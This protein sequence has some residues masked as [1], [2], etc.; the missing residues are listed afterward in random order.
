[1]FV[2]ACADKTTPVSGPILPG[3]PQVPPAASAAAWRF[4]VNMITRTVKITPPSPSLG[5]SGDLSF[6]AGHGIQYSLVGSDVISLT[7]SNYV[8]SGVGTGGAQPGRVLVTFDLAITNLLTSVDLITPTFPVPPSGVSGLFAFPF[9]TNVTTTTGGVNPSGGN[10]VIIDVPSHGMVNPS[11]H[12]GGAPHNFFND[13][14][15]PAG[16]NDCY[17]NEVYTVPLVAG[18][19]T[20]GQ[21]VGFDVDATVHQFSAKV[22]VAADLQNS[23]PAISRTVSGTVNSNIGPLTGGTVSVSGAGSAS[24]TAG[25]YSIPG[26]GAGPHS[27][28]YTPPAG[29]GC[30]TPAS[31]NIT[32]SSGSPDP[33]DVDF[34]VTGCTPP[35]VPSGTVNGSINFAATTGAS[36]SLTGVVVTINPDAASLADATT[37]PAAGGAYSASVG[38]G[39]GAG[40]GAGVVSFSNL[41]TGCTFVGPSTATYTGLT[42]GGNATASAVT[43]TCPAAPYPLT[44]AWGAPSGGSITLTVSIDMSVQNS[45]ANNGASPDLIGAFQSTIQYGTRVSS[46]VCTG[47]TGFTG[48][49]N[50]A[51]NSITAVLTNL[52]GAGGLV[53][54]YSCTFA[55][56]AGTGTTTLTGSGHLLSDQTGADD[57]T[58]RITITYNIIP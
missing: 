39:T 25:D 24:P 48:V 13:T 26:V 34:N 57:F 46:P 1:M 42:V 15:C 20:S 55:Y 23:G 44:Y 14:G 47:Q 17:R 45:P 56:S 18:G 50:T 27:V 6:S 19:T 32:I 49:F 22:I 2:A 4:D 58:S 33:V 38:V 16:A 43:I 51:G 21:T 12:W 29:S 53:T 35:P 7:T 8:A 31:Q 37:N 41:P 10:N 3:D 28:S 5:P 11:T 30:T 54:V 9:A 52:S 40:A 36:P